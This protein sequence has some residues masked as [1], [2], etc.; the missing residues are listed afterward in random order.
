MT[1]I[2]TSMAVGSGTCGQ[3]T[4]QKKSKLSPQGLRFTLISFI[5]ENNYLTK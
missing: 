3:S 2:F 5:I 4:S 1:S